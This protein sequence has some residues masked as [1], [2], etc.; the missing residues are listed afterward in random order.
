[1]REG[2]PRDQNRDILVGFLSWVGAFLAPGPS[3]SPSFFRAGVQT[4]SLLYVTSCA[5]FR[6][7]SVNF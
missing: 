3:P 4:P 2:G 7:I 1:M 5:L 6:Q